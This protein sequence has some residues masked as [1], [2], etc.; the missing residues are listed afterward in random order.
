[1]EYTNPRTKAVIE[2]WPMGRTQKVTATFYVERD[3][4]TRKERAVRVTVGAPK[5][6]TYARKVRICDGDDGRPYILQLTEYGSVSIF[7]GDM[8]Y[9]HEHIGM[10]HNNPRYRALLEL[11][12]TPTKIEV[13]S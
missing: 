4:K 6:L 5:K 12:A 9:Q 7:K 11:F 3:E 8:K 2:G 10:D 13:Q 1:M